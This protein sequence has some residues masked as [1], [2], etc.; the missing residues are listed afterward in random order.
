MKTTSR[1]PRVPF[2]R[3]AKAMAAVAVVAAT[4][5]LATTSSRTDD[6][7]IALGPT[8]PGLSTR[9]TSTFAYTA[10]QP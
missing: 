7:R 9:F 4:A 6:H 5:V 3:R 10:I 2:I 8:G 1:H